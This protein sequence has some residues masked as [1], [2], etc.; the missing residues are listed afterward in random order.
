MDSFTLT[1]YVSSLLLLQTLCFLFKDEVEDF[2]TSLI[3][4]SLMC[5]IGIKASLVFLITA[6][7]F[8]K[9]VSVIFLVI[10]TIVSI[11]H[12]LT[13]LYSTFVKFKH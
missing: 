8:N 3:G 5:A 1:L 4:I 13:N 2:D 7:S 12:I 11:F 9:I 10:F 6:Y